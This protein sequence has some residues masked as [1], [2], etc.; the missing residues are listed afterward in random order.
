MADGKAQ[1]LD[2]IIGQKAVEVRFSVLEL[3]AWGFNPWHAPHHHEP[4]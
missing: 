2:K 1:S 4:T 3:S